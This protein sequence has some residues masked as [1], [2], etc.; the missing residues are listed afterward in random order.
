MGLFLLLYKRSPFLS[1]AA[2]LQQLEPWHTVVRNI[3]S[4]AVVLSLQ[5]TFRSLRGLLSRSK[6][7][8]EEAECGQMETELGASWQL[9]W[10]G[11]DSWRCRERGQEGIGL[12]L[13]V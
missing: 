1:L 3:L 9:C 2:L 13:L 7:C 12:Q 4:S 6:R 11:C 10:K 5:E 8:L